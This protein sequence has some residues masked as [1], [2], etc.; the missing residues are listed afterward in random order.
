VLD[1]AVVIARKYGRDESGGFV[2]GV[3]D[4]VARTL[5]PGELEG[6]PAADI[7]APPDDAEDPARAGER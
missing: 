2:N 7:V 1:E 3:L 4:R 6:E 5:R